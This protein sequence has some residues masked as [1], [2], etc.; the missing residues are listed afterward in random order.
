MSETAT[1]SRIN[2][3][4][5]IEE[6]DR[7]FSKAISELLCS[8]GELRKSIEIREQDFDGELNRQDLKINGL[9][10]DVLDTTK[11]V[12]RRII[13]LETQVKKLFATKEEKP[14]TLKLSNSQETRIKTLVLKLQDAIK[15]YNR[16]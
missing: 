5:R 4:K 9:M 7:K 11:D 10:Q 3:A 8:I 2:T 14:Y 16:G 13:T 6:M 15:E 12:D 1:E